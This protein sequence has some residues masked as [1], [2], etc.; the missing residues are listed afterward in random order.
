MNEL[1][2]IIRATEQLIK[3]QDKILMEV[4]TSMIG[5]TSDRIFNKGLD[6]DNNPIGSYSEGYTKRRIK[7]GLGGSKKVVV[8]FSGQLVNDFTAVSEG[9]V[10]GLGTKNKF[11]VDI[12]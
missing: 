2:P 5:V 9:G 10:V 6:S 11:N 8:T 4:A 3:G 7:K 1:V 12:L